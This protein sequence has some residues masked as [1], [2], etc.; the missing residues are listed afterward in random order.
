MLTKTNDSSNVKI[1][2]MT[3]CIDTILE[4]LEINPVPGENP[5][6]CEDQTCVIVKGYHKPGD[7]GGGTFFWDGSYKVDPDRF[8]EGEDF[9]Y[10]A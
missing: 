9:G 7:G 2:C 10:S 6:E 5:S 8:P 1:E 4:L 3:E